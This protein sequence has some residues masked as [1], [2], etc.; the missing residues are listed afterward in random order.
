MTLTMMRRATKWRS[1]RGLPSYKAEPPR[2]CPS[3]FRELVPD[4]NDIGANVRGKVYHPPWMVNNETY[5]N[6]NEPWTLRDYTR[7]GSKGEDEFQTLEELLSG[8]KAMQGS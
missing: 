4:L 5:D 6:S 8:T 2:E 7:S 3:P 1:S